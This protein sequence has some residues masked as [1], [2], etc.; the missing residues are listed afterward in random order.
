MTYYGDYGFDDF[1]KTGATNDADIESF[2]TKRLLKGLSIDLNVTGA[3]C[4]AFITNN[5]LGDI[6]YGRNFDFTYSPSLQVFTDPDN[7][8]SSVS[9]V[10]LSF[11][12]YDENYLPNGM[13]FK[14]FLTLAAPY[15]PF[16]GMNEKAWQLRCL[17]YQKQM[18]LKTQTRSH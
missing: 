17:P 14:S 5:E 8:Y 6:I 3:G 4:T 11:A 18:R 9:T 7:G 16:D 1:L 15:L 13:S 2:V 10:N 12:G